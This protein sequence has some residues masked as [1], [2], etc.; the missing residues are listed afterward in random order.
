MI[1]R[2]VLETLWLVD[3][4]MS[5]LF[6]SKRNINHVDVNIEDVIGKGSF[7]IPFAVVATP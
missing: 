2:G 3:D 1:A 5:L 6:S 4:Y 7:G